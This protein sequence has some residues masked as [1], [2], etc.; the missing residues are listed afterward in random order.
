[1]NENDSTHDQCE[2]PALTE[3][4]YLAAAKAGSACKEY[5]KDMR[6]FVNT[7]HPA[8]PKGYFPPSTSIC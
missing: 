4:N 7:G 1:M 6:Q 8:S 5:Q 3:A 2:T